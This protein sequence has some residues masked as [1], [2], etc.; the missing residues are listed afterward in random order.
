MNPWI[1]RLGILAFGGSG[2]AYALLR[3][4]PRLPIEQ[5]NGVYVNGCCASVNLN[6]GQIS[7][8]HRLM[9]YVIET[10]KK[11]AYVLPDHYVGISEEN[12]LQFDYDKSPLILRLDGTR[13][14]TRIE[15]LRSDGTVVAF[16][17]NGPSDANVR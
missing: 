16:I 9:R 10:D 6:N 4:P 3:D 12:E 1:V 8:S 11:G 5:A 17:R 15:M 14:P 2:M 7:S 13:N